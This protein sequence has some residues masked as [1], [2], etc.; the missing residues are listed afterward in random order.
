MLVYGL[1]TIHDGIGVGCNLLSNSL[2]WAALLAITLDS[3]KAVLNL[4]V[5]CSHNLSNTFCTLAALDAIIAA[6]FCCPASIAFSMLL[7]V[8]S[9]FS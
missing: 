9:A 2:V 1:E 8:L 5:S 6:V 4:S 3:A 7:L